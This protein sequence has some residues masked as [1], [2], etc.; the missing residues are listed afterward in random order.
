MWIRHVYCV[1][2]PGRGCGCVELAAGRHSAVGKR[3]RS[4]GTSRAR[5][6]SCHPSVS[7]LEALRPKAAAGLP[8][9]W[10]AV[11][12]PTRSGSGP[13][14]SPAAALSPQAQAIGGGNFRYPAVSASPLRQRHVHI[15]ARETMSSDRPVALKGLLM[16]SSCDTPI[17][18]LPCHDSLKS[19]MEA[20]T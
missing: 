9:F 19:S 11:A 13:A 12:G 20:C 4:G 6:A 7:G 5:G 18:W 16:F 17:A 3:K 10:A 2:G 15:G 14:C 1:H 8:R